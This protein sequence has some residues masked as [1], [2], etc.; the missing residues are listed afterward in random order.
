MFF[1]HTAN[2]LSVKL[3]QSASRVN[4]PVFTTTKYVVK[5]KFWQA[6]YYPTVSDQLITIL[7]QHY[8]IHTT[9]EELFH[10]VTVLQLLFSSQRH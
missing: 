3:H 10:I 4:Q 2:L 6:W 9:Y 8:S 5:G 1:E 7:I